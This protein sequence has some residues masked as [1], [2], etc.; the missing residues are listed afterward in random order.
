M[1]CETSVFRSAATR[2]LIL[3]S[4]S[5]STNW[6]PGGR[7]G[8][9]PDAK[10]P[11]SHRWFISRH[12]SGYLTATT[13]WYVTGLTRE[14]EG[15]MSPH[16]WESLTPAVWQFSS[17][18]ISPAIGSRVSTCCSIHARRIMERLKLTVVPSRSCGSTIRGSWAT[19]CGVAVRN[20]AGRPGSTVLIALRSVGSGCISWSVQTL[21]KTCVPLSRMLFTNWRPSFEVLSRSLAIASANVD[22]IKYFLLLLRPCCLARSSCRDRLALGAARARPPGVCCASPVHKMRG[23]VRSKLIV[24][25]S[26]SVPYCW[27]S[28]ITIRERSC[29]NP[30]IVDHCIVRSWLTVPPVAMTNWHFASICLRSLIVLEYTSQGDWWEGPLLLHRVC[31][32][33]GHPFPLHRTRL[34]SGSID[35]P[36]SQ[37]G[38]GWGLVSR[39]DHIMTAS[40]I[41]CPRPCHWRRLAHYWSLDLSGNG[42]RVFAPLQ[43]AHLWTWWFRTST[44]LSEGRSWVLLPWEQCGLILDRVPDRVLVVLVAVQS[45]RIR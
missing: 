5:H 45:Q 2:P 26:R 34:W 28:S 38:R 6:N 15:S 16:A 32:K 20:C 14:L 30:L 21:P 41:A 43:S 8:I 42:T 9:P 31:P 19:S 23:W 36:Q 24:A 40:A 7:S 3:A 35:W 10:L 33:H 1:T 29:M 12:R 27:P 11:S 18:C 37:Y 44:Y 17:A 22:G 39:V 4:V 25:I 13:E